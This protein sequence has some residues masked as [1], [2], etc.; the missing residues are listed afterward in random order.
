LK[1]HDV[2]HISFLKSYKTSG[3]VQPLPPPILEND[4]LS[5]DVECV[6]KHEVRGSRTMPYKC[7]IIKWLGYGLEHNSWEPQKNL[8]SEVLKEYWD[9]VARSQERL[10][11][12]K[13]VESVSVPNK[14]KRRSNHKGKRV[15]GSG[16]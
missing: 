9:T 6:L 11:Q 4:E 3:K 1:I 12:N 13:G 2:F 15:D 14:I 10:T 7:Y 16:V 5:F 8:S